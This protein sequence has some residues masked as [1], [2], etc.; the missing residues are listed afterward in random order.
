MSDNTDL[1][2]KE[3]ECLEGAMTLLGHCQHPQAQALYTKI[4][5]I[6]HPSGEERVMKAVEGEVVA[7]RKAD[8]SLSAVEAKQRVL[9]ENPKLQRELSDAMH[10]LAA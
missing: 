10:G 8:P 6:A 1:A 7:L 9:R 4:A 2:P 5:A 3:Q